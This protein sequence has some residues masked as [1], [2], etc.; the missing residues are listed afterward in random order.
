M[1][2]PNNNL[3]NLPQELFQLTRLTELYLTGNHLSVLPSKI[4]Q[5]T[6]LTTL[7]LSGNNLTVLPK[8]IS[9]LKK[10]DTFFIN[11]NKLKEVPQ[12]LFQ[13]TKITRLNL[14]ENYLSS[15]PPEIIRLTMLKML[16]L[17]NNQL[18]KIPAEIIQLTKLKTLNLNNNFLTSPP[19]EIAKQGIKAIRKYFTDL[20]GEK[21]ELAEVKVIL[22]GE[23]ASGKTSL[24]RILRGEPFNEKEAMTHGIRIKPWIAAGQ[25]KKI[26]CKLWDFGGQ[27]IMHA[28]HQFFLSRRSLYVLVLDGRKDERTEHWLRCI[29]TFGGDSPVLV[30]LNKYDVN[31]GFDLNQPFLQKKYPSI[32]GFYRTSCRTEQGVKAFTQ[33]LCEELDK[34]PLTRELWPATWFQAKQ[35]LEK[36]DEPRISY[37]KFEDVCI[38]AGVQDESSRTVLAEFLHDLGVIIHFTDFELNDNHV[39][40]PKWVT[41]AVYRIINSPLVAECE[42]LLNFNDLKEI[43][44][45]QKDDEHHYYP[46]D[47]VYII[48]L[49]KKFELCYEVAKDEVLI[50]DLLAVSEPPFDFDEQNSLRFLLEY[51]DFFPPSIMPRFIVKRHEE[52]KDE[53]RWR[54]GVVL[55]HPLLDAIAAVRAD[56][57]AKHVQIM[58]NGTERKIFLALIWLTFRELHTGFEDLKVSERIPLPDNPTVS[59]AY[60]TLLNYAEQEMEKIIPEG[61]DKAYSVPKLLAG[62]HFDSENEGEK[63]VA[64]AEGERKGG[65]MNQTG[66]TLN[67]VFKLEPSVFGVGFNLNAVFDIL[68]GKERRKTRSRSNS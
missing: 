38:Q 13:L 68:L 21:K 53:L 56:N 11:S 29:E 22:V 25:D 65:A 16:C 57:E 49:M 34:V 36:M 35:S 28:T 46:A 48:E 33:A 17:D 41:G 8:E 50:P 31:P 62:V 14:S 4:G 5:L 61:T 18:T 2:V 55:K 42:G 45:R 6:N 40:D 37:E 24:T 43:L 51:K 58:V 44:A 10:L 67:T 32:K 30:V 60:K 15:L 23:G 7:T 63:M 26:R 19:L 1:E 20:E 64:L 52:I 66:S 12:E 39:L 59:V 54:T 3:T 27:E 9:Q 47:H